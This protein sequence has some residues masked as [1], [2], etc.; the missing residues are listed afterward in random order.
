MASHPKQIILEETIQKMC[1]ELDIYLEDHFGLRYPLHPNRPKRGMT[2]SGIYD[3]LFST[4]AVFTLGYGSEMGRGYIIT[5]EIRTLKFVS[6]TDKDEIETSGIQYFKTLIP[7]YFPDRK[8]SVV[9]DQ[10]VYKLVGDFSL[11]D[12]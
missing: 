10:N 12:I 4:T 6:K 3:G 5:I 9:K 7:K 8:L 2:A 1:D 11:G